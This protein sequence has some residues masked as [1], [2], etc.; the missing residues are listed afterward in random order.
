MD[1]RTFIRRAYKAMQPLTGK[2][3]YDDCWSGVKDVVTK[4]I[5]CDDHVT[6]YQESAR[7]EGRIGEDGF[8]KV[9]RYTI[10]GC[11]KDVDMQII[12]SFCGTIADPMSAYDITVFLN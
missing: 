9:Y 10:T 5:E 4:V 7:Y 12:A 2:K 1:K 3:Y 8:R 6:L 11:N